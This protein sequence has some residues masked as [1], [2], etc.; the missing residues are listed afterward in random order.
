MAQ[1]NPSEDWFSLDGFFESQITQNKGISSITIYKSDKKD[2][3]VFQEEKK[4]M[5]FT[6]STKGMLLE[7]RKFIE[8]S[9]RTDT[10]IYTFNYEDSKLASRTESEGPFCFSYIYDSLNDSTIQETKLDEKTLDTN[11]IHHINIQEETSWRRKYTYYNSIGRPMKN[12]WI[13]K[14]TLG[15][16]IA[17]KESYSRSLSFVVDSFNYN[18]NLLI[19]R[20]KWNTIGVQKRTVWEFAY[21]NG[22]LDFIKQT[23]D[24]TLV[25][26]FAILYNEKEL[27]KSI[28]MRNVKEKTISIYKV[29]YDY[30]PTKN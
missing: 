3:E 14:N 23:E 19:N 30:F 28:V 20:L 15:N 29:E 21:E 25:A 1:F 6:F 13:S 12:C 9:R 16:V 17:K 18:G 22:F 8:L 4:Y 11:Y 2:D 26:K 27:I 24:G 5:H 10:S 7:S